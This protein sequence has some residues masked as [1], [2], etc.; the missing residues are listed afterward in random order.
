MNKLTNFETKIKLELIKAQS[1]TLLA[2]IQYNDTVYLIY[3]TH[4]IMELA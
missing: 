3:L 2:S 1:L 4:V